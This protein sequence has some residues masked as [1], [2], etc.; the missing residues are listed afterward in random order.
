MTM[1]Y[2]IDVPGTFPASPPLFIQCAPKM[3]F[4]TQTQEIDKASGKGKWEAHFLG[5]TPGFGGALTPE[6]FKVGFIDSTN[7]AAG[8][9]PNTPVML[10]GLEI[11]VMAKTVRDKNTGEE[12]QV[13]VHVWH[14]AESM[15]PVEA[16]GSGSASTEARAA[17]AA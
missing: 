17:R 1:T 7:P 11:G 6:I 2:K 10:Q 15:H 8:I 4:G 12:K 14:R 16:A 13:G 3:A 5:M 9:E